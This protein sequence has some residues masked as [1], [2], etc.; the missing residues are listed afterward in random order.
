MRSRTT[1]GVT[2]AAPVA[3]DAAGPAAVRAG[4]RMRGGSDEVDVS[5]MAVADE[6]PVIKRWGPC[7]L[8]A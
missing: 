8:A 7:S 2:A 4:A 3:V 1:L 5:S 6:D